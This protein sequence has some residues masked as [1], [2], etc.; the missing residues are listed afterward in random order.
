MPYE[1]VIIAE[2]LGVPNDFG[3]PIT[4]LGI[5]KDGGRISEWT[6]NRRE[7]ILAFGKSPG[8]DNFYIGEVKKHEA[9]WRWVWA[10]PVQDIHGYEDLENHIKESGN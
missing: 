2:S 8:S 4:F 9:G 1:K 5:M 3:K 10:I 6:N 7:I